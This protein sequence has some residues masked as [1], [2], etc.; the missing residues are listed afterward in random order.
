MRQQANEKKIQNGSTIH[1]SYSQ[2]AKTAMLGNMKIA[3]EDKLIVD[4]RAEAEK[5]DQAQKEKR[6]SNKK[7]EVKT[8]TETKQEPSKKK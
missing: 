7:E 6:Q 5:F 2:L 1:G 4:I 8:Q 3:P